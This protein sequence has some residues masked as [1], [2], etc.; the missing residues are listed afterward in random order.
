M[1]KFFLSFVFFSVILVIGCQENSITDPIQVEPT[2]TIQK[3]D[4]EFIRGTFPLNR[5]LVIPGMTNTYYNISGQISYSHQLVYLDPVPPTK[6]FYVKL[7]FSVNAV[8]TDPNS[9]RSNTYTIRAESDVNVTLSEKGIYTLEKSFPIDGRKDRM[10][11]VCRF[12][13]LENG[14]KLNEYWLSFAKTDQPK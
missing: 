7:H 14:V 13:V 4:P 5:I 1:K 9:L 11:L 12:V 10:V 2:Q 6:Q 8:L 3:T